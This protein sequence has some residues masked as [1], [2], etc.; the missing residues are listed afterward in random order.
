[1]N[2]LPA[3]NLTLVSELLSP[4]PCDAIDRIFGKI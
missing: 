4:A 1:M 3:Q 2:P